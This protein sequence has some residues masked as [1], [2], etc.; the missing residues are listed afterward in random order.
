MKGLRYILAVCL[1]PL[2]CWDTW[3]ADGAAV[4][5][6]TV[7][8]ETASSRGSVGTTTRSTAPT[9]V[10]IRARTTTTPRT[11]SQRQTNSTVRTNA[12][13]ATTQSNPRTTT[14]RAA[15]NSDAVNNVL[16]RNY[17]NCKNVFNECMDEFCANKDSQLKRC[18][19]SARIHDF[20]STKKQLNAAEDKLLDFSQRLLT[21][22]LDKE[23]ALA[24]NTATEGELAFYNTTDTS[25]SK[26][27]LDAIAKK[28]NTSFKGS[29]F[30]TNVSNLTWSLNA[31]SAFDSVNSM[32]GASTT[33]KNGTALYSAALPICREMAREVCSEYELTIAENGYQMLIAQDCNTVEK[34]YKTQVDQTRDKILESSALLDM[35]R[36]DIYQ[37]R[38]S[39]DILT[40]KGKMLEMLTDNTVCGPTLDKCLDNTG[41]YINP[42]TGTAFLTVNLTDLNNLIIRPTGNQTWASLNPSFISFLNSKRKY[43][44]TASEHCQDIADN[45]WTAFVEDALAQIKLAQAAKLET[46]RQGCTTLSSQCLTESIK[47]IQDFDSR[48]LSIFGVNAN[49]TANGMCSDII[50]SCELVLGDDDSKLWSTGM[51]DIATMETYETI[52]STCREVGRSCII[53]SCSSI[54][55]N[56][57]LCESTT[58][59]V[60][61]AS[62]LNRLACW[63]EVKVCVESAGKSLNNIMTTMAGEI[64][65]DKDNNN[66]YKKLYG[67]KTPNDA[68]CSGESGDYACY[69]TERIWGNCDDKPSSDASNKIMKPTD[70]Q[71]TTLLSWFASNTS[72]SCNVAICPE[73][74]I[75]KQT[76]DSS[77]YCVNAGDYICDVKC[78]GT[79]RIWVT[80]DVQN[81]CTTGTDAYGNCCSNKTILTPG[82]SDKWWGNEFNQKICVPSDNY[83]YIISYN[84]TTLFCGGDVDDSDPNKITCNNSMFKIDTINKGNKNN[85][86]WNYVSLGDSLNITQSYIAD[87]T[88]SGTCASSVCTFNGTWGECESPQ[89]WSV[90]FE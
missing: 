1:I 27:A 19:C 29:N 47:S 90:N 44:E 3:A 69:L 64:G 6:A 49:K 24:I 66:F 36:L 53:R 46:I 65:F 85:E 8:R 54:S 40:C 21:V 45:V 59:S 10:T 62:I 52:M 83:K 12:R 71:E 4:S 37:Q 78:S 77:Y 63:D 48:A 20:D 32:A 43:I 26:R 23:D 56:F 68:I 42:T 17:S 75:L 73:G 39:D 89:H 70:T 28:L 87:T 2:V 76:S 72:Y 67:D 22:N 13:A 57:G 25:Q 50:K 84:G 58:Y 60:N 33:T 41:R 15:L 55:G 9:K 61:R 7:R 5:R 34:T 86:N 88:D 79:K 80:S 16:S 74:K 31:D 82:H 81:C 38:N 11:T 18:A 14:A 51:T 35:S 30:N